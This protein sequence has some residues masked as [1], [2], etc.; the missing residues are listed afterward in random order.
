MNIY[1]LNAVELSGQKKAFGS[2]RQKRSARIAI[3]I[4]KFLAWSRVWISNVTDL[5]DTNI[6]NMAYE[7]GGLD[8]TDLEIMKIVKD[9]KAK[10]WRDFHAKYPD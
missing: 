6:A 10:R 7:C 5:S 3:M 1:V 8:E 4:R 9:E 2:R